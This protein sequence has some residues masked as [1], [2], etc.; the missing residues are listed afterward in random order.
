MLID[1]EKALEL[2]RQAKGKIKMSPTVSIHR[3]EDIAMAYIQ[4]SACAVEEIYRDPAEV[5][6]LTGKSNRIAIVSNGTAVLGLGDRSPAAALPMIEGKSLLYKIFGDVDAIPLCVD[7]R[8]FEGLEEICRSLTPTF[9]AV[10]IEDIKSPMDFQ[11]VNKLDGNMDVPL[12][13]DDMESTA[14]VVLGGLL[15]AAKIVEKELRDM[16]IVVL[17]AG[18]AGMATAHL[19]HFYGVK[20]LIMVHRSGI[21]NASDP[22]LNEPQKMMLQ[23]LNPENIKGSI[24]EAL[25]GADVVVGLTGAPNILNESHIGLMASRPIVFALGRT[26]PEIGMEEAFAGGA[27]IAATSNIMHPNCLPNLLVFPGITRG[28]LDVRATGLNDQVLIATA[29]ELSAL[30]DTRRLRR[31]HFVPFVLSDESTP[32]I[33]EVVAQSCIEQGLAKIQLPRRQV[34]ES[35]WKRL[36]GRRTD[37]F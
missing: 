17:G 18:T 12:L 34:Y 14:V 19:L 32:R 30:V 26:E 36:Y 5:Y 9:A 25:A 29:R 33:A 21:L 3:R 37:R 2:H 16:K 8:T 1:K 13:S 31:D 6:D 11:L 4:G 10:V 35:T 28:L 27:Y 7:C 15:N 24:P 20:N 23:W 22:T